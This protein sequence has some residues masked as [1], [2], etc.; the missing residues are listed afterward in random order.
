MGT[1]CL[2]FLFQTASSSIRKKLFSQKDPIADFISPGNGEGRPGVLVFKD[3]HS[4]IQQTGWLK[5]EVYF[6]QII[7]ESEVCNQGFG[8]SVHPLSLWVESLP[9][10]F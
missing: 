8:R 7:L 6:W 2:N 4:K 9:T 5:T 1:K 3:G 10:S